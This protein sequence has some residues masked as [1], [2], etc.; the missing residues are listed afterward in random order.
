MAVITTIQKLRFKRRADIWLDGE[1]AFSLS[2]EIIAVA[3]LAPGRE[4]AA[5]E[6]AA[7]R[8]QDERSQAVEGALKLLA[9]GPRS[10]RDLRLRLRRRGL[11]RPAVDHALARM[12]ELGYLDDAAFA[13]SYVESRQAVTPRSRRFLAFELRQKGVDKDA[14]T[15]ALETVADE[16]AAYL[17]AQRRLRSLRGVDHATF[18]R[19]LGSFLAARGFGYGTARA[20]IDRC[21]RE[22]QAP[23]EAPGGE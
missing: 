1:R 5:A 15:P 13:R 19:R 21:W 2:L 22:A 16:E 11:G 23:A 18:Q 10:E 9:L 14:A 12:R 17:A 6:A 4:L 3:G 8:D 20:V 7:L